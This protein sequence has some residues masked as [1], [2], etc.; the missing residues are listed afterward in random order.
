MTAVNPKSLLDLQGAIGDPKFIGLLS[1][2][3][4]EYNN[5]RFEIYKW[6]FDCEQRMMRELHRPPSENA[7]SFEQFLEEGDYSVVT[8]IASRIDYATAKHR[9]ANFTCLRYAHWGTIA[10][11]QLDDDGFLTTF[12]FEKNDEKRRLRCWL[13]L[14]YIHSGR[15]RSISRTV[16]RVFRILKQF[17]GARVFVDD[18][19]P[20]HEQEDE[21]RDRPPY[22]NIRMRIVEAL[23]TPAQPPKEPQKEPEPVEP[24]SES[25]LRDWACALHASILRCLSAVDVWKYS[26]TNNEEGRPE[27]IVK[28]SDAAEQKPKTDPDLAKTIIEEPPND[29]WKLIRDNNLPG[30]N[31]QS[32]V[33]SMASG[34]SGLQNSFT[35]P[36]AGKG[37]AAQLEFVVMIF[38]DTRSVA[39]M[40]EFEKT[41]EDGKRKYDRM[42]LQQE[43][44]YWRNGLSLSG[45]YVVERLL[46]NQASKGDITFTELK[47]G[48]KN[49]LSRY[50]SAQ[51]EAKV[52]TIK[53]GETKFIEFDTP[54]LLRAQTSA[55]QLYG[56]W[57]YGTL[58][59][60]TNRYGIVG[61]RV[62]M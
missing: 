6:M 28:M 32:I 50:A 10:G 42:I 45:D 59:G 3:F 38:A 17:P 2:P 44:Y 41:D 4:S 43:F 62:H 27:S 21:W 58:Y 47:K 51:V 29:E 13:T 14:E 18:K 35:S 24:Y 1:F 5:V 9:G 12:V 34:N 57:E 7:F 25:V 22:D 30:S 52:G 53:R 19:T 11:R 48:E 20:R 61:V 46:R 36:N 31:A 55:N 16:P 39:L 26:E 37:S 23:K 54:Y 8:S 15:K 33:T 40:D 56:G 60:E 49:E